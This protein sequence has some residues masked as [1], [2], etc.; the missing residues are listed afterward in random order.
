MAHSFFS[1]LLFTL[2]PLLARARSVQD[3]WTAPASPDNS[4]NVQSGMPFTI[5]WK[6]GLRDEVKT[7]CTKCDLEKLDL[8][9]TSSITN[10]HNYQIAGTLQP[11]ATL[12]RYQAIEQRL[13][14]H[15]ES[16]DITA[17]LSHTWHVQIPQGALNMNND[18]VLRFMPSGVEP[19][20]KGQVSSPEFFISGTPQPPTIVSTTSSSKSPNF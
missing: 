6:D 1:V 14:S 9:V 13:T 15:L 19:P 11:V 18:W 20:Y 17:S 8:W 12:N 2:L 5:R 4:T 10:D 16:V 3:E 7:S